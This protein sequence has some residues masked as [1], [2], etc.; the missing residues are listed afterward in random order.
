M[1][2]HVFVPLGSQF[3]FSIVDKLSNVTSVIRGCYI[4]MNKVP[5]LLLCIL[6]LSY[7]T[8]KFHPVEM[9]FNVRLNTRTQFVGIR[10]LSEK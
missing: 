2:V 7:A 10:G 4:Y 1:I 6:N 8:T 5:A 3:L 9:C